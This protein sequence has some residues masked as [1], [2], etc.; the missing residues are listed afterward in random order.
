MSAK[1]SDTKPPFE[2]VAPADALEDKAV[3]APAP[4]PAGRKATCLVNGEITLKNGGV[5][6]L[7]KGRE[8]DLAE[9]LSP[10]FSL[11]DAVDPV[12]FKE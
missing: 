11:A 9:T 3:P 12:W 5:R 1:D 2:P 10:G 7:V 4:K 8:Y 6:A